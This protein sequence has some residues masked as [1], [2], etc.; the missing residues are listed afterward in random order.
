MEGSE[1][2]SLRKIVQRYYFFLICQNILLK[3][4]CLVCKICISLILKPLAGYRI[5]GWNGWKTDILGGYFFMR[6][7]II[8]K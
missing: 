8:S 6:R 2:D 3:I 7:C 1:D 5:M 4:L